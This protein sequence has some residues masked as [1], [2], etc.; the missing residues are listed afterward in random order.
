MDELGK[1]N[2]ICSLRDLIELIATLLDLLTPFATI[3]APQ[4]ETNDL[5][6]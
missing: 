6:L 3:I 2:G 1:L 4:T 5:E